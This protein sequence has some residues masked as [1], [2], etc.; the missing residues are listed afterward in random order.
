MIVPLHSNHHAGKPHWPS[1]NLTL[2]CY[3]MRLYNERCRPLL[4]ASLQGLMLYVL[5]VELSIALVTCIVQF[6][7]EERFSAE[8]D[9]LC[10]ILV[11]NT[12]VTCI[13]AQ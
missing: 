12:F 3:Q 9:L 10:S 6:T 11:S 5:F 13:P 4:E 1:L 7:S 2:C 8:N